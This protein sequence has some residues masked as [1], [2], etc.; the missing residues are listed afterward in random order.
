MAL[1]KPKLRLIKPPQKKEPALEVTFRASRT[2]LYWLLGGGVIVLIIQ[3]SPYVAAKLDFDGS[4]ELKTP[5]L[6]E[7]IETKE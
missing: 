5:N 6:I 7:T 1:K 3:L 4:I 2:F